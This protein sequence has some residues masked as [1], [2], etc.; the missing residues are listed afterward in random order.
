MPPKTRNQQKKSRKRKLNLTTDDILSKRSIS[1][2][3][4]ESQHK[5]ELSPKE[6]GTLPSPVS[7]SCCLYFQ[8]K[9]IC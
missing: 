5:H 8:L 9:R 4:E 1:H 3:E 7:T 6:N 2:G